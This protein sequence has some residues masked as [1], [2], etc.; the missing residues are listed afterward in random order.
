MRR[1]DWLII[2]FCL[3]GCLASGSWLYHAGVVQGR[4]EIEL[5]YSRQVKKLN[6]LLD[7]SAI[8]ADLAEGRK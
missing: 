6:V 3:V 5:S 4:Q 7:H 1:V 2:A 8:K